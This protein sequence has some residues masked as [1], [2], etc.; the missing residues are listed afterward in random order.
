MRKSKKAN[1]PNPLKLISFK[2]GNRIINGSMVSPLDIMFL[3]QFKT[4]NRKTNK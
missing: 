1:N 3:L 2:V 4:S